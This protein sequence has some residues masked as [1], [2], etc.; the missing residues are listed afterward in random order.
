MPNTKVQLIVRLPGV[1]EEVI[2]EF[3]PCWEPEEGASLPLFP[4]IG[5]Q[6]MKDV[7]VRSL[8]KE[9][10]KHLESSSF[11]PISSALNRILDKVAP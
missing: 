3:T 2:E 5:Q 8:T 10:A 6:D 7:V 9:V 4:I 1:G 11:A